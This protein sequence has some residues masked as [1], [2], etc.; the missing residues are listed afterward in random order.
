[1]N[2]IN[3]KIDERIINKKELIEIL[4]NRQFNIAYKK[5]CNN[6]VV[7]HVGRLNVSKFLKH[8]EFKSVGSKNLNFYDLNRMDY[9]T[10]IIDNIAHIKC[11]AWFIQPT[12]NHNFTLNMREE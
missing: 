10:F 5:A 6:C 3:R 9:R 2:R 11:G 12:N 7:E 8:G 1:M 4:G